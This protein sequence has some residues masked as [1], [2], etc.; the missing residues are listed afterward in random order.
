M[1]YHYIFAIAMLFSIV[2]VSAVFA[3]ENPSGKFESNNKDFVVTNMS[4]VYQGAG[5]STVKGN[6][7]VQGNYPS[8][9]KFYILGNIKNIGNTTY[10]DVSIVASLYN[11]RSGLID[12]IEDHPI[13]DVS[14]PNNSSSFKIPVE[15]HNQSD[16]D[17]FVIQAIGKKPIV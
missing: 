14:S 15:L 2:S 9:D 1:K 7:N 13:H 4:A 5:L 10:N 11:N 12:L 16:F 17:H 8:V 3:L 6:Y